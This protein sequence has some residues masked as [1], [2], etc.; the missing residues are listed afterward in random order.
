[1]RECSSP[2]PKKKHV[3]C[4]V[5][6]V[7][8]HV[9]RVC[10]Q[11][12]LPRLVLD[13]FKVIPIHLDKFYSSLDFLGVFSD[14]E[15]IFFLFLSSFYLKKRT[16][17]WEFSSTILVQIGQSDRPKPLCSVG[18]DERSVILGRYQTSKSH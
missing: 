5:S 15:H 12:D 7:M 1:M 13:V 11:R 16:R 9:S 14:T 10:Y 6:R 18:L 4:H 3:T 2:P 8:C 17:R